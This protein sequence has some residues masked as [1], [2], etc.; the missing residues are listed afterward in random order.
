MKAFLLLGSAL[1]FAT[2]CSAS[3][4]DDDSTDDGESALTAPVGAPVVIPAA[5][6]ANRLGS[7]GTIRYGQPLVKVVRPSGWPID[8]TTLTLRGTP[9]DEVEIAVNG[10]TSAANPA[11][12][13]L[14]AADPNEVKK[15]ES[16]SSAYLKGYCYA[17][18]TRPV[19]DSNDDADAT[20]KNAKLR[21]KLVTDSLTIGV[22]GVSVFDISATSIASGLDPLACVKSGATPTRGTF[23][24]FDRVTLTR[25]CRGATCAAWRE[26]GRESRP[27][28]E[29]SVGYRAG[30]V[31]VAVGLTDNDGPYATFGGGWAGGV[32]T[33]ED[34]TATTSCSLA[35]GNVTCDDWQRAVIVRRGATAIDSDTCSSQLS[36]AFDAT[37]PRFTGVLGDRCISLHGPVR[38]SYGAGGARTETQ[39]FIV[40]SW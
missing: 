27:G 11:V 19:L 31:T 14:G 23:G 35:G 6:K 3:G 5:I 13:V 36:G 15:C 28:N 12:V 33:T 17:G 38:T 21:T 32:R 26:L 10:R 16:T 34:C 22:L 2:A 9:G 4:A 7:A 8:V 40:K 29:L 25:D 39:T 1:L 37:T 24:E 20:T 18:L 30:G